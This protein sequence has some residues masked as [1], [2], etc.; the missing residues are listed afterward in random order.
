MRQPTVVNVRSTKNIFYDPR[1]SEISNFYFEDPF[2][3]WG[4]TE[5]PLVQQEYTP[6]L[7]PL[8]KDRPLQFN[9][10]IQHKDHWKEVALLCRTDFCVELTDLLNWRFLF[11]LNWRVCRTNAFYVLK[12]QI[13]AAEKKW[14]FCVEVMCWTDECVESRGIG[15]E[16]VFHGKF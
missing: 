7:F 2:C 9:T 14:P 15:F 11:V 13:S 5:Y 6:P 10:S 12:W 4:L 1:E 16:H 3:Y 8:K